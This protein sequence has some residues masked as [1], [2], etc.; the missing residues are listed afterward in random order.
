MFSS[1]YNVLKA[2]H[3]SSNER[4]SSPSLFSSPPLFLKIRVGDYWWVSTKVGLAFPQ[5]PAVL[6]GAVYA[7]AKAPVERLEVSNV[8]NAGRKVEKDFSES[9]GVVD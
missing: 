7:Q 9:G 3:I 5:L 4:N 8:A 6:L 1:V 2:R